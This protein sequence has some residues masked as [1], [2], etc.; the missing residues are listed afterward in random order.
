M[1]VKMLRVI[2]SY[3]GSILKHININT[4]VISLKDVLSKTI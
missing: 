4:L 3:E 2:F 1:N